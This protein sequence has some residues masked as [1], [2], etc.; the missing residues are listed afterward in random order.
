MVVPPI[1]HIG[2]SRRR[3]NRYIKLEEKLTDE[4]KDI[5]D[6]AK[7]ATV[8]TLGLVGSVLV[9]GALYFIINSYGCQGEHNKSS[10]DFPSNPYYS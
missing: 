1:W 8:M 5:A 2:S 9:F 6:V 4:Q 3:R 10:K 7:F